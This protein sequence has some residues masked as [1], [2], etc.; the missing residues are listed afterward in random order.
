MDN[1]ARNI[2]FTSVGADYELLRD[3]NIKS[4]IKTSLGLTTDQEYET[5]LAS[6]ISSFDFCVFGDARISI[7]GETYDYHE[8]IFHTVNYSG[9]PSPTISIK[10]IRIEKNGTKGTFYFKIGA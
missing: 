10:S 3:T 2:A 7:N 8:P 9:A 1:F 6:G 4:A 5:R